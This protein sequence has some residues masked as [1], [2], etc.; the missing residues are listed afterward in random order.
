V[1][2]FT[3]FSKNGEEAQCLSDCKAGASGEDWACLALGGYEPA[4]EVV[5]EV[6]VASA[7]SLYCFVVANYEEEFVVQQRTMQQG[8]Y[9][10]DG[11]ELVQK[12][13]GIQQDM[14][15]AW[16]IV[17][18]NGK[19]KDFDWVVRIDSSTVLMP[20]RLRES[21]GRSAAPPDVVAYFADEERRIPASLAVISSKALQEYVQGHAACMQH[22]ADM[23]HGE[24][25]PLDQHFLRSCLRALGA[26]VV[27]ARS[28]KA[29]GAPGLCNLTDFIAYHSLADASA[30]K[31]CWHAAATQELYI[32]SAEAVAGMVHAKKAMHQ[33]ELTFRS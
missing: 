3:C 19:Y 11:H 17:H 15:E 31:S 32:K 18:E 25:L 26:G 33:G 21:L 9:T 28:K 7:T 4:A 14:Y 12:E 6:G 23:L 13:V 30:W 8:I 10:C 24:Q 22:E 5:A 29:V 27:Q 1:P 2:G 16:R 20:G